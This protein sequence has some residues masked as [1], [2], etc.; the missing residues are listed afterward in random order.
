[1]T[2]LPDLSVAR[3]SKSSYSG[4]GGQCVETALNLVQMYGVVPV[5]DS[6]DPEGPA[7]VFTAGGFSAFVAAAKAGRFGE[8]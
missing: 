4:S 8:V 6:K 2:L 7:L 5:R 3:W 1:M